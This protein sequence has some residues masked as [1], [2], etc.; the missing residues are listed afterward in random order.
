MP[1]SPLLRATS[2]VC[3]L[4]GSLALWLYSRRARANY[5]QQVQEGQWHQGVIVFPS[6]DVV[7]R[8]TGVLRNVDTTIDGTYLSRADVVYRCTPR[9]IFFKA[10][11]L[12]LYHLGID[13]RPRVT[14]VCQS[15]VCDSV[16]RIADHI[17]D[18]KAHQTSGF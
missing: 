11:Y 10:P 5:R 13:A 8:F 6:G 2:R 15:D 1:R 9:R 7:L 4:L 3:R 14:M 16:H 12:V 18:V 17:N